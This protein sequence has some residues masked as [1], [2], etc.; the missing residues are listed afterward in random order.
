MTN[1]IG[2]LYNQPLEETILNILHDRVL[3][4]ALDIPY[5]RVNIRDINRL[6]YLVKSGQA[7][8]IIKE[9]L[10]DDS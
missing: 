9:K 1:A 3:C 8:E 2:S 10:Y 6:I 4:W 7:S 5:S